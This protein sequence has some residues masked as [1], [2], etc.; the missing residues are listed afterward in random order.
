MK[1]KKIEHSDCI[2][3]QSYNFE[4]VNPSIDVK[5][6]AQEIDITVTSLQIALDSLA[7]LEE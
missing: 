6:F 1:I 5:K 2:T 7:E 4:K 3:R